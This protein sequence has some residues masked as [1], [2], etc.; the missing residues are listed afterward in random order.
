MH[1]KHKR[2]RATS[3]S[4]I[5]GIAGVTALAIL[6]DSVVEMR[7]VRRADRDGEESRFESTSIFGVTAPMEIP[8]TAALMPEVL[9]AD[10][11]AFHKGVWFVLDAP[12]DRIHRVSSSGEL[13]GSFGNRG[14]GPG[15]FAG[16]L[17]AI[18]A[19]GDSIAVLEFGGRHLHVFDL[20]GEPVA[21][22][23][24]RLD[25]CTVPAASEL[26]SSPLGLLLLVICTR[27]DL[28]QE[29]RVILET[30]S[31]FMR[32]LAT[33]GSDAQ[34]AAILGGLLWSTLSAH[35]SGFVF[36]SNIDECLSV[37]NLQ[38]EILESVCHG[39]MEPVPTPEELVD[40]TRDRIAALPGVR[41]TL[42][43]SFFPFFGLFVTQ[44]NRWIY[45][46]A[47]SDEPE[48][49]VLVTLDQ[50]QRRLDVPRAR[51]VF[52]H[53]TSALVGWEDLEGTRIAIFPLE[54]R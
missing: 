23:I 11:A 31:G 24:L 48:S 39:W 42:P 5:V 6:A 14:Q 50:D 38:G 18:A 17:A 25:D 12:A 2:P 41:W 8:P 1:Q 22:R 49:Y 26:I 33:Q 40:A 53:E 46:V 37:Y 13:L 51:Y 10:D 28:R 20:D 7:S 52:L 21:D 45:R 54:E 3:T 30:K 43:E 36:G 4:W 29:A 34:D 16:R 27:T 32:T 35:P 44:D 19:H 9:S 47:A 15:E